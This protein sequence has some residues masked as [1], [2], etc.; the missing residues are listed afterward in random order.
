MNLS[1]S[2]STIG[3]QT[4]NG[5]VTQTAD[6]HLAGSTR[7]AGPNWDAASHSLWLSFTSAVAVPAALTN[8]GD[9]TSDGSG[10]TTIGADFTTS[11]GQT[12]GNAVTL[13]ADA[14]LTGVGITFKQ[15]VDSDATARALTIN[16]NGTTTPVRPTSI[17]IRRIEAVD[18]V[19]ATL[20]GV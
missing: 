19:F 17:S 13:T 3:A 10:G 8:V 11:G 12:Y 9:F 5:P 4:Y 15:T 14:A 2:I 18:Q 7:S 1:G 6:A 20:H 16:D